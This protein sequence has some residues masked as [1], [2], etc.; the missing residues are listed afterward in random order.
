MY[1]SGYVK[2]PKMVELGM[3]F[4]S[5]HVLLFYIFPNVFSYTVSKCHFFPSESSKDIKKFHCCKYGIDF[6]SDKLLLKSL[7][8]C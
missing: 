8:A 2:I 1:E 6:F 7:T 3:D 5:F 4:I